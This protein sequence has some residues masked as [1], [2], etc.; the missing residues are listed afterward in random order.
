MAN[1]EF[2]DKHN[3]VAYLKKPSGSEGFQEIVDFLNGSYIRYAL[4]KNP[5]IYVSLIEKFWQTATYLSNFKQKGEGS[6]HHSEP[7]PPPCTAQPTNEEP[8]PNV[9]SSSHQKT[10]TPRKALNKVIE[11][12]KTSEPIPNARDEAVYEEWDDRVERATTTAASLDAE[13]ASGNINRTQSTAIPNVPLH[14]GIGA[15]GSPRVH[16][17]GSG[18]SSMTLQELMVL[19]TTLSK[20]VESLEADLK[21]TKQVYGAAYTKLIIKVKKLEKTIKTSHSRRR[22]K[23]VVSDDEEDSED[24]SK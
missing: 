6:E 9:V 21:Q 7:Q 22:A 24:S 14:Q 19:C 13:Q 3:M 12:H 5:T 20:K 11:L 15:G 17:L 1:F 16:T 18:E 23:I 2:C 10:Q 8:I 4:T